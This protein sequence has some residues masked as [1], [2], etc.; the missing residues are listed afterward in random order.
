MS[1][2]SAY[3]ENRSAIQ[4]GRTARGAATMPASNPIPHLPHLHLMPA[5]SKCSARMKIVRAT[6]TE[7]G[8]KIG[9][10]SAPNAI[11]SMRSFSRPRDRLSS[12]KE[13]V[14]K[15]QSGTLFKSWCYSPTITVHRSIRWPT[16]RIQT[17]SDRAK[18]SGG[19][20]ITILATCPRKP[21]TAANPNRSN[22]RIKVAVSN[23]TAATIDEG[24]VEVASYQDGGDRAEHGPRYLKGLN[25]LRRRTSHS[26]RVGIVR[27]RPREAATWFGP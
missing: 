4:I 18:R 27:P 1:E 12:L 9:P 10:S 7:E 13:F 23:L 21:S 3:R 5:C 22:G 16:T 8:L 14:T 19:S 26:L 24:S 11:T 17:K 15:C 20:I 25:V 2:V 6:P